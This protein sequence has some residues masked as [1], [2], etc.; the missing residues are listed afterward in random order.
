MKTIHLVN[1]LLI[2]ICF[3]SC[4]IQ[5]QRTNNVEQTNHTA[6]ET[7]EYDKDFPK[8]VEANW[9]KKSFE[10]E[11]SPKFDFLKSFKDQLKIKDES[12]LSEKFMT[13]P[14]K[15]N[16]LA[17][18][19]NRKLSW[20]SVNLFGPKLST[21]EVI[22]KELA[23][24][25]SEEEMLAFYYSTIFIHILNNQ[26]NISPY[27]INLDFRK[28]GLNE[29]EGI[30]MFL[31]AMRHL[32]SQISSYSEKPENCWRQMEFIKKIP[33]F[34]GVTFDK[35]ELKEFEDFKLT[36]DKRYPKMSFKERYLPEFEKAKIGYKKCM[37]IENKN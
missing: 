24:P 25:P 23:T 33:K 13:K 7:S 28:L 37:E 10:K 14:S 20:N 2:I 34:N 32:G 17:H 12:I 30:I 4:T 36:V 22:G 18:Y 21:R 3:L 6:K 29:K 11:N 5:N 9:E 27:E 1:T 26:R 19:L 35:F 31:S 16:L 8:Y 15:N